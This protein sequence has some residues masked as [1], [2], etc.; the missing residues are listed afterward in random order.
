MKEIQ[1]QEDGTKLEFDYDNLDDNGEP[2]VVEVD[3]NEEYV[4]PSDV[5]V[6]N[7]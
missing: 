3:N 6:I 1:I 4:I 2:T 5:K 7:N